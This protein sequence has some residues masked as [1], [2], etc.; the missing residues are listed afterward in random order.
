MPNWSAPSVI[1]ANQSIAPGQDY[2]SGTIS[3]NGVDATEIVALW[4]GEDAVLVV[5]REINAVLSDAADDYEPWRFRQIDGSNQSSVAKIITAPEFKIRVVNR[6]NSTGTLYLA[7]RQ[8]TGGAASEIATSIELADLADYAAGN[9]SAPQSFA[10]CS[11]GALTIELTG[12]GSGSAVVRL[13]CR[14]SASAPWVRFGGD[15]TIVGT[16]AITIDRLIWSEKTARDLRLNFVSAPTG[17]ITNLWW[18]FA[19]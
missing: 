7:S 11:R 17:A 6:G 19:R 12:L 16:G 2:L 4:T 8:A 10:G 15:I 14:D 5:Q 9:T 13:E 1:V 3:N 18:R